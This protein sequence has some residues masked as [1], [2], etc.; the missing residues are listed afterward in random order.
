MKEYLGFTTVVVQQRMTYRIDFLANIMGTALAMLVLFFFWNSIYTYNGIS[1]LG[2]L[3]LTQMVTYSL[4]GIIANRALSSGVDVSIERDVREGELT[5]VLTRPI[6]YQIY[7]FFT[8]LGS[9]IA[10]T[11]LGGVPAFIMATLLFGIALPPLE[12]LAI[13]V[14]SLLLAFCVHFTMMF[15]VG[16]YAFYTTGSIGGM[17]RVY[18]NVTNFLS[19]QYIPLYLFPAWLFGVTQLLPFQTMYNIPVSIFIGKI[20]GEAIATAL[21]IQFGW[22]VAL[23]LLGRFVWSRTYKMYT[24][25]GG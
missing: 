8:G 19:G 13:F 1:Q 12:I 6:D 7:N 25:Q 17:R 4:V 20:E 22:F 23:A 24:A 3:T 11:L 21:L 18:R 5:S 2:G 15:L 9:L 14:L 10:S 16:L